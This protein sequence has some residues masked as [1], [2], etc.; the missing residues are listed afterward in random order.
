[1]TAAL[2][3]HKPYRSR[4]LLDLAHSI[5]ECTVQVPGVC[6]GYVPEGCEPAHLAKT[7]FDGGGAMK[8]S[9]IFAASCHSCAVECD[10]GKSLSRDDRRFFLMRGALRTWV[11]LLRRGWLVIA[12]TAGR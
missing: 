4:S 6:V 10:Q 12:E 1:M 2:L 11:E 5:N 9:D 7:L 8:S 3:K